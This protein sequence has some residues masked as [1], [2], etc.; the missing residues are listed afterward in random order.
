MILA[1]FRVMAL[2]LARDRRA[3]VTT[4]LL[5]PL[6][7]LLASA[8]FAGASG[9]AV[10]LRVAVADE[11][12]SPGSRRLVSALLADPE[13]RVQRALPATAA[14]VR[15]MVKSGVIDA[16]VI[17]VGDLATAAGPVLV[18]SDPSRAVAAPLVESRVR[19]AARRV[20]S[21]TGADTSRGEVLQRE[22]IAGDRKG[23]G[24]IAYYAG[25]VSVLFALFSAANGALSLI[26]ERRSGVADRILAG[27]RG[28]G[29]VVT[30]KFLFLVL[31]GLVQA[32][33]VFAVAQLVYGLPVLVHLW[34]WLATT[35]AVS[36][37][38]AGL[39]LA[40]VAPCRTR[41]QAQGL[42]TTL[43]LV[44]AAIGGALAPRFLMPPWLQAAGLATPHAWAIEAYQTI[45]WRGAGPWAAWP[46]WIALTVAGMAGL[47]LAQQ[48]TRRAR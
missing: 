23:G 46:A 30:G 37:C 15:E 25:A 39:A 17:I 40:V 1:M 16:G 44:T 42:S 27:A 21:E 14:R 2:S 12:N 10:R 41:A 43:I 3:L 8:V 20:L 28:M 22:T 31:Q 26:D 4:F 48:A 11:V 9:E 13:L 29:P 45:L 34:P 35:A 5:P 33:V 7:F 36:V 38:A 47:L 19:Q 24:S 32:T 6:V 18:V